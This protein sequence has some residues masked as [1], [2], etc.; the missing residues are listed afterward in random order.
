MTDVP[1]GF[2]PAAYDV[3]DIEAIKAVAAGN[4][5]ESQQKRAMAWIVQKAALTYDE[6]FAM[7][8]PDV[9][10]NL[11]GR[12]NVGLQIVKLINMPA[13]AVDKLKKGRK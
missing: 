13:E 10:A 2:K 4:A 3:A 5:S 1:S 12:R 7:G 9:T 11:Q 8:L 6:T